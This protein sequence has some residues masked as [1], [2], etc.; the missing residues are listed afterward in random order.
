[1]KQDDLNQAKIETCARAAHEA[2]RAYCIAIG[3]M[4]R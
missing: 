1:M 2:N 3:N 4:V